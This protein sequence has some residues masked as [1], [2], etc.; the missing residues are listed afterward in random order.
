[1]DTQQISQGESKKEILFANGNRA[2]LVAPPAGTKAADILK[3]L[4]IQQ[5][6]AVIIVTGGAG[7]LDKDMESDE[8]L[9]SRLVQLF[10]R[11]IARA[12]V[13]A[14]A[15]IIDGGT[16]S[17]VMALMGQGVADRGQKSILLGVAPAG[18]VTYPSGPAEGSIED[19]GAL[20]PNH[21]HF[22]LV[23]SDEWGGE[24]DMMFELAAALGEGIPVVTVL[25]HGRTDGIAKNEA[26]RSVRQ[27]WPIIV[28]EGSGPLA[29]EIAALLRETPD[30]IA[31]PDLAE[32]IAD[33]DLHLFA[34]DGSVGALR[35]LITRE[36]G[37]DEIL[38]LAW[39]R[40]ATYDLHA[41]R[42]RDDFNRL[43]MWILRL[44]V[45][46]TLAVVLKKTLET[47]DWVAKL[48]F[49][50]SE[51]RSGLPDAALG[52]ASSLYYVVL[53]L[54]IVSS[55]LLA[56]A[57]KVNAGNKWVL[58]RGSA[59][60]IKRA[61][62]RYRTR[63]VTYSS[64]QTPGSNGRQTA[65]STEQVQEQTTREA[66]LAGTVEFISRQLMQSNV[67]LSALPPYKGRIP[68]GY[69]HAEAKADDGFSFLTPE[70]FIAVRLDDQLAFYQDRTGSK[71]REL[72]EYQIAILVA[73][74]VGTFLAAVGLDLWVALTTALAA[75]FTTYLQ[76]RQTENTLMQYNQTA[77][78]LMNVKGWWTALTAEQQ[79][80]QENVDRLVEV[81]ERILETE[82]YGWVQQM[83]DALAE[84][85]GEEPKAVKEQDDERNDV[86]G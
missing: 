21:T 31:D 52:L 24:T 46:T 68:P 10:S 4:G 27:G 29:D 66:E 67:N 77:T 22:V 36:F 82:T 86:P 63:R 76:Y 43:R 69:E 58:L 17:G 11:G 47:P 33:S 71:E 59:E 42:H 65:D 37:V 53:L 50:D 20:D 26:L 8:E 1:M 51:F 79:A 57:M 64:P 38:Q 13:D 28:V 7:G 45:L 34:V 39:Q 32:I 14:D 80:D 3:T 40:F 5:P 12:A 62:F 15:L 60:A 25:V 35:K 74:G 72:R 61:M 75:A 70:R 73:G 83:Q 19:G 18:K 54:P 41:K 16:Q 44:G 85:R 49:L 9:R 78:N 2:Q 84:L 6:K 48:T 81:T 30:F 23:E 55:V 56:I